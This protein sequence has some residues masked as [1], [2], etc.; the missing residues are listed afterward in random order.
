MKK[1]LSKKREK[2]LIAKYGHVPTKKEIFEK[3]KASQER[4]IYSLAGALATAPD[5]PGTREQLFEAIDKAF[6]LR[7]KIYKMM[8]KKPPEI[9][10]DPKIL[11]ELAKSSKA[12]D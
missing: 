7:E 8:D 12:E 3:M 5:D 10:I 4:L 11:E 2:E 9:K 6:Q 1:K